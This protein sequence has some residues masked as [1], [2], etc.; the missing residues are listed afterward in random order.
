MT[1]YIVAA[2]LG[3]LIGLTAH[4]AGHVGQCVCPKT[5][6]AKNG[7]IDFKN[8]VYLFP[9]P[10]AKQGQRL[11]SLSGFT[12]KAE[13]NGYIQLASVPD[14]SEPDPDKN[15]GKIVGWGKLADFQFQELR[16]C[17]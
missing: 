10:E 9:A 4:A 3:L 1:K 8:P 13:A 11:E 2:A 16:N 5:K 12:I 6:P 14:Y 15:A 7:A 17:N